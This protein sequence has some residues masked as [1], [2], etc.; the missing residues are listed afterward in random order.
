[1][2]IIVLK[3]SYNGSNFYGMAKQPQKRTVQ[4]EVEKL[5]KFLYKKNI[6]ISFCSRTDR[7]VHAKDQLI[8]YKIEKNIIPLKGIKAFINSHA[9]DIFVKKIWFEE[10]QIFYPRSCIKSKLYVYRINI[11]SYDVFNSDL[12]FQYNKS[13]NIKKLKKISK[14]FIGEKDYASFTARVSYDN[15][16]KTIDEIKVKRVKDIIE[17][18]IKG[19]SFLRYMVRNV[20]GN[21]IAF[22]EGKITEEEIKDLFEN[23]KLGKSQ[24]KAK[25]CGLYLE[26]VFM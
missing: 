11:G 23:S 2:K 9:T 6:S 14:E 20:V 5:L 24:Y 21:M 10:N 17:I 22:S 1:M 25:G 13:L 18:H 15:Y 19:K 3:I 26:K 8:M 16:K 4:S 7:Y 12:C